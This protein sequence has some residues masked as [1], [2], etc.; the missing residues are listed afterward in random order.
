MDA[1]QFISLYSTIN[2]LAT[3]KALS[4]EIVCRFL[5]ISCSLLRRLARL[6]VHFAGNP[7][8]SCI[9]KIV[10]V[11]LVIDNV[12]EGNLSVNGFRSITL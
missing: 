12:I 7:Q 5:Y 2:R 8:F 6:L 10:L 4:I 1:T 11:Q 9:I 3:E